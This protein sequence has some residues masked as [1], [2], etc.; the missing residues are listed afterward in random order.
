[1]IISDLQL[2]IQILTLLATAMLAG[3]GVV[4]A[5]RND[6]DLFGAVV[7]AFVCA[8]GGG[9]LRDLLIGAVP[10][11]WIQDLSFVTTI[12]I[13]SAFSFIAIRFIPIGRGWRV[14]IFLVLDAIGLALFTI[15]GVQKALLFELP[16]T[17][18]VIMGILT[19][20]AGGMLRDVLIRSVPTV[21]SG[22]LYA[23]AAML[24]ALLY[25][26]LL[27]LISETPAM[28]I[29]MLSIFLLRIIAMIWDISIPKARLG[30]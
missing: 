29:A 27:G 6:L 10:V 23:V 24:G 25:T 15:L 30:G 13:A 12:L 1:M 21:F 19:G 20:V 7:L 22:Q 9:T 4:Q 8:L 16:M 11:F 17:I 5:A 26:Q 18:A 3:S 28:L 2:G 14:Q